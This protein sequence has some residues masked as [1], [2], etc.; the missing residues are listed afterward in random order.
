MLQNSA[1]AIA[2]RP[3]PSA[4]ATT[5]E[6][7]TGAPQTVSASTLPQGGGKDGWDAARPA[8]SHAAVPKIT[9]VNGVDWVA[10]QHETFQSRRDRVQV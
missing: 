2:L 4:F 10:Q 9:C 7:G 3:G 8:L 6:L 5:L 1:T